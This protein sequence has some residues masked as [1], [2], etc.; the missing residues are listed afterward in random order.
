MYTFALFSAGNVRIVSR[1]QDSSSNFRFAHWV[2]SFAIQNTPDCRFAAAV[3][4]AVI[5]AVFSTSGLY[6]RSCRYASLNHP[7]AIPRVTTLTVLLSL[8]IA[9]MIKLLK[10]MPL[11]VLLIFAAHHNRHA[12]RSAPSL[13]FF[14][15]SQLY[16]QTE[17]D[18]ASQSVG[19]VG[20]CR[21]APGEF[22]ITG[23][24]QNRTASGESLVAIDHK[25][26]RLY[27]GVLDAAEA[28]TLQDPGTAV[29]KTSRPLRL[30]TITRSLQKKN[31][32]WPRTFANSDDINDISRRHLL[33]PA[34]LQRFG[35]PAPLLPR[36][37]AIED[38]LRAS[39][40]AS[41][42]TPMQELVLKNGAPVSGGGTSMHR[43]LT[44]EFNAARPCVKHRTLELVSHVV[45][46]W[47]Q[48]PAKSAVDGAC[49]KGPSS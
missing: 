25:I 20:G 14:E 5:D 1:C 17:A 26:C 23:I 16:G 2:R 15:G 45:P 13:P 47:R 32:S 19:S 43:E 49:R 3:W 33:P 7:V 22:F 48:K 10:R 36:P 30:K 21:S 37:L 42:R 34:G 35:D 12:G 18:C 11:P 29:R 44:G 40:V 28:D 4:K 38:M 9:F 24:K 31:L 6:R 27:L 8:Q 41:D 46:E 39:Q